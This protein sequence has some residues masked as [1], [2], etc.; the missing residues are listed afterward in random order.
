MCPRRKMIILCILRKTCFLN[1]HDCCIKV[2]SPGYTAKT[3]VWSAVSARA[4][5]CAVTRLVRVQT[6]VRQGGPETLLRA[7][8]VDATYVNMTLCKHMYTCT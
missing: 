6:G 8:Q 4:A 3:A 2:A 1:R 5:L 7:K